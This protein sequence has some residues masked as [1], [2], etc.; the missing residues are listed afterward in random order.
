[1]HLFVLLTA[2]G[3]GESAAIFYQYLHTILG[4]PVGLIVGFFAG[5]V[6]YNIFNSSTPRIKWARVVTFTGLTE[7]GIM[8][9]I[10]LNY[11]EHISLLKPWFVRT[12]L[13]IF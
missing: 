8:S 6:S 4:A 7:L 9:A 10:I 3:G 11:Y 2:D 13:D 12:M 1:M 5:M